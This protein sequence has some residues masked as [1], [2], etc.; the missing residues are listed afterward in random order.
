MDHMI[1][2]STVENRFSTM[3]IDELN[4]TMILGRQNVWSNEPVLNRGLLMF[5]SRT[6]TESADHI[7][8]IKFIDDF[9]NRAELKSKIITPASWGYQVGRD[10]EILAVRAMYKADEEISNIKTSGEPNFQIKIES[11]Q[12][13]SFQNG[14]QSTIVDRSREGRDGWIPIPP[15]AGEFWRFTVNI[16]Q[17]Y[18]TTIKE[19][20]GL[21]LKTRQA[22]DY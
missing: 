3:D 21:Q 6:D 17:L 2:F 10:A 9:T 7:D 19:F 14:N 8:N 22:G 16:P 4:A 1:V 18:R 20:L 5:K 13:P 15:Q 12:D 11:S